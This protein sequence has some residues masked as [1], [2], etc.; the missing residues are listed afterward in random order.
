MNSSLSCLTMNIRIPNLCSALALLLS[1]GI[2]QSCKDN[3]FS[4]DNIDATMGLGSERLEL[5][6]NNDTK[7]IALDDVVNLNNSDF[8][9]IDGNGDYQIKKD[10]NS[11][12]K[13]TVSIA[14]FTIKSSPTTAKTILI[15]QGDFEGKLAVLTMSGTTPAEVED[16][17]SVACDQNINVT[18]K[19]PNTVRC[20]DELTL[21]LPSFLL[22]D[23][24]TNDGTNLSISNN[25][26]TLN[27][28]VAGNHTMALYVK[29]IDFKTSSNL[30]ST[31]FDKNNHR[32][33]LTAEINLK[34]RL[35]K[36]NII[37]MGN[38]SSISGNA[39]ADLTITAATGRFHPVFTFGSFGSVALNNIPDF[40]SDKSVNMN[41][42]DPHIRL[43]FN[44]SLPIAAKVS[45]RMIARD[46]QNHAIAT[47][48]IPTFT[49]PTGNSVIVLHKQSETAPQGQTYVPV[50][51]L[52]NLLKTI[53]DH[54]DFVDIKAEADNSQTAT[55]KLGHDYAMAEQ[56]SFSTPLQLDADAAIAYTDSIDDLNKTV[57]KLSFKESTVGDPTSING[58]LKLEA[59]ITNRLP[60][61]LTL[62]AWGTNLQGDSIPQSQ[63]S[64]DVDKT[65]DAASD[66]QTPATTHLTVTIKP[67]S[68]DVLHSL[69]GL[70]FRFRAT[71][72]DAN[73][74]NAIVG[75]TINAK[76]QTITVKN[77][78]LT[79][80]GKLVGNFN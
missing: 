52:G 4:F 13:A 75:K 21:S 19:V 41:L 69:E 42:Y 78:K 55:V 24:A 39:T 74:N 43:D 35:S 68:N 67:Q 63:L 1:T 46:A 62:T 76:T 32:V 77:I 16:L 60:T 59:D 66:T 5:P 30:G 58:S 23:H 61:Y 7:E 44:N 47:V 14:H 20:V 54:I 49:V 31:S 80:T 26:I 3:D 8:V 28:T 10:G 34:G 17:N 12:E 50:P 38:L 22:I 71:A 33:R 18:I 45:G 53:P 29:S 37:N 40:L 36:K 73:G 70:Q 72:S 64:V 51:E 11:Q 57:K 9:Y 65:V 79:K 27:N 25:T 6:G 48:D 15:S 2:L 56:Y